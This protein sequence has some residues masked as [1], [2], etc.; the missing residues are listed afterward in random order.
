MALVTRQGKGSRL[1]IQEMD[2]N[3]LY[4]EEGAFSRNPIVRSFQCA[5]K[6]AQSWIDY[7]NS[8]ITFSK[9][10][11]DRPDEPF[12]V[13]SSV[14]CFQKIF[15]T[16]VS[17]NHPNNP[18]GW[19]KGLK[20]MET[21]MSLNKIR[22]SP[23][24]YIASVETYAKTGDNVDNI[25]NYYEYSLPIRN[26]KTSTDT[27]FI[28]SLLKTSGQGAEDCLPEIV[29]KNYDKYAFSPVSYVDSL[30]RI[31][32]KG[33]IEKGKINGESQIKTLLSLFY[34]SGGAGGYSS[35][36]LP[37]EG[38]DFIIDRGIFILDFEA[39]AKVGL[40]EESIRTN[41]PKGVWIGSGQGIHSLII[42]T[43]AIPA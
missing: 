30:D 18:N 27:N 29:R 16:P 37:E 14:E 33:I 40:F 1:T 35:P 3:L 26:T 9:D 22:T 13:I 8:G 17:Q 34:L 19:A 10:D 36:F 39:G 12:Y 20:D 25:P 7:M 41:K 31:F 43:A 2:N 42:N 11:V 4:L 5:G 24:N 38:L 23:T 6:N 28:D 15:A 32:D 21:F